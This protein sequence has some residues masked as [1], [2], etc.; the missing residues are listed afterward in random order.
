[1]PERETLHVAEFHGDG[2]S[3]ELSASVHQVAAA[4]PLQV[5]FH[6]VDLTLETR[7][8]DAEASYQKA[9]EAIRAHRLALKYPTV[10]A[11]ES[12]NKVLRERCNF[13]VI[14]RPV[15]SMPGVKSRHDGQ[16]DLHI[17]RIAVGGTYEDA[18]RRIGEEVAVSIRVIERRPARE[19]ALF[20]FRL[21]KRL[22]CDVVSSSKY[23]IQQAT[24]GFFEEI[25][26][27]VAFEFVGIPHRSE[28]FDSLLYKLLLA[29]EKYRIVV[30][31]NE[32]GDF[33]SDMACGI[34]GSIGLGASA[35]YSFDERGD[36]D[37]AMFDPAGGTAPDIAGKGV[38]NPSAAL[39]AFGMLLTHAGFRGLGTMVG[40]AV[41]GAIGAGESTR[42]LGGKLD[43]KQFTAAVVARLRGAS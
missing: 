26:R 4:L 37:L 43:T 3:A 36:V 5:E 18:G 2:I 35:N 20:A 33:L 31:P 17:V 25:V 6:G 1:M 13:S 14:H 41:A 42:D 10:T 23:T 9:L 19:A 40:E 28:L 38:C 22:G 29:P 30:T 32:Y 15:R 7:R 21:A 8:R 27:G 34:V 24:D 16:V 39:L 11:E 12:P